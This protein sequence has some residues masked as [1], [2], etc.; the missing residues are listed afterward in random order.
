MIKLY[1]CTSVELAC[2]TVQLYTVHNFDHISQ[3]WLK[4]AILAEF[5]NFNQISKF[6]PNF[7]ILIRLHNA[8]KFFQISTKF[9]N[10]YQISQ[11]WPNFTILIKYQ[12]VIN[13]G[14]NSK[15]TGLWSFGPRCLLPTI[16]P[17]MCSRYI[18]YLCSMC[19]YL[20]KSTLRCYTSISDGF[21]PLRIH[22]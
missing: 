1:Y 13:M 17:F 21:C 20:D 4:I 9:H 7:T 5:H 10:F 2:L 12:Y 16:L 15:C 11:F 19:I 22:V 8:D 3:F 14:P 6:W 18:V